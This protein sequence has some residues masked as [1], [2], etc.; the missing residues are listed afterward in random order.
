MHLQ[1]RGYCLLGLQPCMPVWMHTYCLL[2]LPLVQAASTQSWALQLGYSGSP[3]LGPYTWATL[4]ALQLNHAILLVQCQLHHK[5]AHDI[6][7][8]VFEPNMTCTDGVGWL[9][10]EQ[11]LTC[12]KLILYRPSACSR[13]RDEAACAP[14]TSQC[15]DTGVGLQVLEPNSDATIICTD[16]VCRLVREQ[17]LTASKRALHRPSAFRQIMN[18]QRS[19]STDLDLAD[20]EI[21]PQ[22]SCTQDRGASSF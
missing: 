12:S 4:K 5:D 11:H 13:S 15:V 17:D 16:G 7:H 10:C 21:H 8:L 2:V 9:V 1:M 20:L 22:G 6:L 14:Q 19:V 18:G 3:T